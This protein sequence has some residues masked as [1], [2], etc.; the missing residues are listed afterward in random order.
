MAE[1]DSIAAGSVM[2]WKFIEEHQVMI[3]VLKHDGAGAFLCCG[4]TS[5]LCLCE[6]R[7]AF[8]D[9]LLSG[10]WVCSMLPTEIVG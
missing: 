8:M 9:S 1:T 4:M 10:F 7:L 6:L 5:W 2:L 3:D